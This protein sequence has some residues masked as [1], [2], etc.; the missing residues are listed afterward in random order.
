MKIPVYFL[1][2]NADVDTWLDGLELDSTFG[3]V[4]VPDF[5]EKKKE[6]LLMKWKNEPPGVIV[7]I[8][9]EFE[10]FLCLNA[11][12]Y[13]YRRRWLYFKNTTDFQ[14]IFAL[15]CY[16]SMLVSHTNEANPLLSV[17]TTS[18]KSKHRILRPYQSLLAQTYPNWEWIII[19]D[20]EEDT[21][22][23]IEQQE[24]LRKLEQSDVRI[25][26]Y[27]PMRHNGFI[28]DL[29]RQAAGL[30]HGEWLIEMDHDDDIVPQLF[31][32]IVNSAIKYPEATFIYSDCIETFEDSLDRFSYGDYFGLG[33]GAYYTT[34][35]Q[36]KFQNVCIGAPINRLCMSHIVGVPNH[37]RCWKTSF[38]H[39]I[40]GHNRHLP[41][42]DDY[43]LIV[44]TV[45]H[46]DCWVRIAELGYIQYRN[47]GGSNFT[48]L[49][50][51]LIQDLVRI[52]SAIYS[53]PLRKRFNELFGIDET[54]PVQGLPRQIYKMHSIPY[55]VLEKVYIDNPPSVA[56]V[57]PTYNRPE[58]LIR[59][60]QSVLLQKFPHWELYV[61]GD[62]CPVLNSVMESM[63]QHQQYDSRIRWWNFN[64]NNGAGGA[65]PRNYALYLA[66]TEWIAYLD[67]D[68]TWDPNHLQTFMDL[69]KE[70]ANKDVK[71]MF[72]SFKVDGNEMITDVPVKGSLD[73]SCLFHRRDLIYKYG[74]WKDRK[75]GG[76]AHDFEFFS[77]FRDEKWIATKKPTMNYFTEFNSQSFDTIRQ[78]YEYHR[79]E[80]LGQKKDSSSVATKSEEN[81]AGD[82]K[83]ESS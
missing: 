82:A 43:E 74:L 14:P 42:A 64:D 68:N 66:Q 9:P 80:Y 25:R 77:R 28:G 56:I 58:H 75:D 41:V 26:V 32:W 35:Y 54:G 45:L 7:C 8:H 23:W 30:A 11:L 27:K 46:S 61:I 52:V 36:G 47:T 38:Y 13:E 55:P 40:G 5:S 21:P 71:Y 69:L 53:E 57:M 65:V 51:A 6:E 22:E 10:P 3:K 73:T 4:K 79:T 39:K 29:K 48:F 76:Y 37:I 63:R 49:R 81:E 50:N 24:T 78:L 62:K 19:D 67:D 18:Y 2:R 44:R 83:V 20:T 72:S 60:I 12:P 31:Q 33:Y 34:L 1:F 15:N 70:D 16:A 59:A 17:F